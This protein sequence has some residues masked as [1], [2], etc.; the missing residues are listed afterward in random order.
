MKAHPLLLCGFLLT[1]SATAA[2]NRPAF[3][4]ATAER[5][6]DVEL[7]RK[8]EPPQPAPP[9]DTKTPAPPAPICPMC[10]DTGRIVCPQHAKQFVCVIPGDPEACKVCRGLGYIP[11]PTCKANPKAEAKQRAAEA[12][13]ALN[14]A[15]TAAQDV[16]KEI[17]QDGGKDKL[18]TKITGYVAEHL[19][20]GSNLPKVAT[21]ACA[22]HAEALL[23]KLEQVFHG[24]T[25][26]F[27]APQN[28]RFYLLDKNTEY[29]AFLDTI[30]KP[31]FPS[32]DT[33][34]FMKTSGTRAYQVPSVGVTCYEKIMRNQDLLVHDFV[35]MYSHV[36]L[37]RVAGERLYVPWIEEGFAAWAETLELNA[38]RVYCIQY[39]FNKI[40]IQKNRVKALQ[41]MA[42]ANTPIPMEK[43]S[44]MSF[45]D[46]KADEYFQ[47]WSI[48]SMLIERDPAKFIAFLNALPEAVNGVAG[49]EIKAVDQEKALKETYGYDYP[50]L[51]SVWKQYV[52]ATV[53]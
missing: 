2:E 14:Q 41:T 19:A 28:A 34:L 4:F 32:V 40:D 47:A 11:C 16:G 17:E 3:D 24:P 31:R 23:P 27:T 21:L 44:Q 22:Q 43:L 12:E 36:L 25:F 1:L 45:M 52:L 30:W 5:N 39:D 26:S 9:K 18:N 50:K 10:K 35:H 33:D 20:I 51:L 38:P 53:R 49:G 8:P 42:R 15:F 13:A 37:N 46:M 48:V 6:A 29:K 7:K